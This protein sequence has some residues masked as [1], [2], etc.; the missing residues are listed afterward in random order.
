MLFEHKVSNSVSTIPKHCHWWKFDTLEEASV[1]K[2]VPT[3]KG[4]KV[5][6]KNFHTL[7]IKNR[8]FVAFSCIYRQKHGPTFESDY[9]RHPQNSSCSTGTFRTLV[10]LWTCAVD[11][12]LLQQS[13]ISKVAKDWIFHWLCWHTKTEQK[14]CPQG[15]ER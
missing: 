15:S 3:T 1:S 8:I 10:W 5:R 2:A 12:Q 4:F 13:R 11:W 7:R 9:S 14:E 6:N